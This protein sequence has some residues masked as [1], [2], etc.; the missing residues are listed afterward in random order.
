MTTTAMLIKQL[1]E[2]TY[3]SYLDC[4]RTL[5]AH[6][7]D[8]DKALEQLRAVGLDKAEKKA[9]RET[10][11]GLVVVERAGDRV[12]AIALA[13][14]TDFVARTQ[15]FKGLAHRLAE[16]VLA[17]P[18]PTNVDRLLAA[19]L[20]GA[21]DQTVA[22]AVKEL[23]GKLGENIVIDQVA[24]FEAGPM[25]VVEGYIHVGALEGYGPGEGRVGVLVELEVEGE[26]AAQTLAHDL[27]HN[28][29]LHIASAGPR[30]LSRETIPDSELAAQR[31]E[32]EAQAAAENKPEAIRAKILEG[33]L[34]KFYRETCL[35]SQPYLKDDSLDVAGWL[36]QAAN[37]IG[38]P[39]RVVRF[40][41][42]ELGG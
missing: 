28:V 39:V 26:R 13:C 16:A 10:L 7:G 23:A 38:A 31:T 4:A 6:A 3:A 5:E 29:A 1:R 17:D 30:Y 21:P 15:E 41:R 25:S 42:F 34:A 8:F 37:E 27:A 33:R 19:A 35:L 14:E 32:L 22:L 36:R 24:R 2:A 18:V 9:E 12:A 11:E 40:A 20:P